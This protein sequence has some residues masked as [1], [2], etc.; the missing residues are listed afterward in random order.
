M[1][2]LYDTIKATRFPFLNWTI[3]LFTVFVFIQQLLAA[4]PES[5][6]MQ[7]ALVPANVNFSDFTT[8][9]PFVTAIFLHGGLMHILANMWFLVVFGDNV[10]D[11]LSP[12]GYLLLYFGAGIIG[13]IVQYMFSPGSVVP[14]IGASGAV[15]GILGCYYVL[16]PYAK[17]KTLIFIF[18]FVTIVEISAPILL[19]YWF[20]LQIIS[21]ASAIPM[22]SADTGGV[23][24]FAHIA[25]F[26]VGLSFGFF[27]K[28]R[29]R[30]GEMLAQ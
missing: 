17:I 3:V 18:F 20:I 13:N 4:D 27:Y 24:F 14:M 29:V 5:F 28:N 15:A 21:G 10:N 12:V 30:T 7:F 8:L 26:I 11:A 25:G 23:A 22:I 19:G 6:I 16:F 1:F 2:P 9:L